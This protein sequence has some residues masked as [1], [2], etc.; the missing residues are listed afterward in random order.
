MNFLTDSERQELKLRHRG[1]RDGR[2]RDRI[3][4]V[5]LY[6]EGWAPKDIARV[7][8]ISDEAVRHHV[9]A[10]KT[11]KKLRPESGGSEEKLSQTQSEQLEAHL[12][13][14]TYLYVK[15]IVAYVEVTFGIVYT[16]HG[17][18]IGCED[19]DFPTKNPPLYP[20]KPT[21]SS[22]KSGSPDTQKLKAELLEDE[23]ICFMTAF[24]ERTMCSLLMG[25]SKKACVKRSSK[26]RTC[27]AQSFR[28]H[29]CHHPQCGNPRRRDF[30][31][32][33]DNPVFPKDRRILP[34]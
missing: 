2:V 18:G 30:K 13:E 5:L 10:Y 8:L 14:H 3:K 28:E 34:E 29:R 17:S 32:R 22:N 24:I 21:K 25:G 1:D 4:A 19:T 31:R 7:L 12:Q 33:I 9:D 27:Q 11:S 20:G 16:V 23:T 26:H 15:D 6:D